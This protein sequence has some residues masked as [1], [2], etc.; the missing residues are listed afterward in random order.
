MLPAIHSRTSCR[1]LRQLWRG[2]WAP[3]PISEC[4]IFSLSYTWVASGFLMC[5]LG[6]NW[7]LNHEGNMTAQPPRHHH[8]IWGQSCSFF[9]FALVNGVTHDICGLL[10]DDCSLHHS[11]LVMALVTERRK[12]LCIFP[13]GL[14]KSHHLI[15]PGGYRVTAQKTL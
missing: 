3:R 2:R 8:E 13:Y 15:S 14:E 10:P 12:R 11:G 1:F 4:R 6:R 9:P 7:A 5:I